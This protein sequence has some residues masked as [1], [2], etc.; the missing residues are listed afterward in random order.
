MWWQEGVRDKHK[1][2]SYLGSL[3]RHLQIP[4]DQL[5]LLPSKSV[6]RLHESPNQSVW[7]DWCWFLLFFLTVQTVACEGS[8]AHLYCGKITFFCICVGP[9]R[10]TLQMSYFSFCASFLCFGIDVG[11]VIFVYGAYYGRLDKTTCSYRRPD[12]QIQNVYCSN[13]TP[14]VAE[15]W[16]SEA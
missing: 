2:R 8:L 11:Q 10:R 16:V 15:R 1:C 3:R 9:M 4:G 13:P 14:K 5:H 6:T 12:S 7:C